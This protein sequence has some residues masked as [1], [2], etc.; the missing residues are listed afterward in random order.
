MLLSVL[1][2]VFSNM[3]NGISKTLT[4]YENHRTERG[5]ENAMTQKIFLLSFLMAYM[6]I[7][8]TAYVYGVY[9]K[10]VVTKLCSAVWGLHCSET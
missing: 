6:S 7:F 3:Y 5:F 1:F 4:T 10:E 8:L 2:P 9:P